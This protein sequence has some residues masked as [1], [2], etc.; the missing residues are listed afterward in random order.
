M[1]FNAINNGNFETGDLTGW[2]VTSGSTAVRVMHIVSEVD[3][4]TTISGI[5]SA[6]KLTT[7]DI[8]TLSSLLYDGR[9]IRTSGAT[10]NA[11]EYINARPNRVLVS[12][13]DLDADTYRLMISQPRT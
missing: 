9:T 12:T 8:N 11:S 7:V 4:H 5:G 2:T 3:G 1:T 6:L 10:V 13:V